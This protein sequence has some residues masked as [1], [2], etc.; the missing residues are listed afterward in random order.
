M[1][2][3]KEFPFR[4]K[5]DYGDFLHILSSFSLAKSDNYADIGGYQQRIL[6]KPIIQIEE[7][8]LENTSYVA[9][10]GESEDYMFSTTEQKMPFS[11][12]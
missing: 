10:I 12:S 7:Q 1:Q 6:K 5:T 2:H 3:K 9:I 4:H 8:R 11:K